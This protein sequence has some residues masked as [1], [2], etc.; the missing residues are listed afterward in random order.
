MQLP[1]N[2]Q[3]TGLQSCI[4]H[5]IWVLANANQLKAL[6]LA[7]EYSRN[8]YTFAKAE[9]ESA[10]REAAAKAELIRRATKPTKVEKNLDKIREAELELLA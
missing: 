2:L 4:L 8:L 6:Q 9:V 3:E 7:D 5:T 1:S 10:A